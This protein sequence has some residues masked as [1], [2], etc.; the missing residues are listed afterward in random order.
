MENT[1]KHENLKYT[2][3][4]YRT[5]YYIDVIIIDLWDEYVCQSKS[6]VAQIENDRFVNICNKGN[7][8]IWIVTH[9]SF[10]ALYWKCEWIYVF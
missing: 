4:F 6:F 7:W 5:T 8:I 3:I 9:V 1:S 2:N 10:Q